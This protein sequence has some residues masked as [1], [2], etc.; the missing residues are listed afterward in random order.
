MERSAVSICLFYV[1]DEGTKCNV[2]DKTQ[3]PHYQKYLIKLPQH[4]TDVQK[5]GKVS[6]VKKN[7][8]YIG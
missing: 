6:S 3:C 1:T 5:M 4:L 2:R 8:L 7:A